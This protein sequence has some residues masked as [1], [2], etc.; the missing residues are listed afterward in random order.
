MVLAVP[1]LS[2]LFVLNKFAPSSNTLCPESLFQP[3]LGLP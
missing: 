1:S 2:L 3:T